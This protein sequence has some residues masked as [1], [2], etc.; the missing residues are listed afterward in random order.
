[1]QARRCRRTLLCSTIVPANYVSPQIQAG[2]PNL[3]RTVEIF[4]ACQ[5]EPVRVHPGLWGTTAVLAPRL[6]AR[7]Q[8]SPG[9]PSLTGTALNTI[10][11]GDIDDIVLR[12]SCCK[13]LLAGAGTYFTWIV[14][15]R[16]F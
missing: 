1:M 2:L 5:I 12:Q 15:T 11:K 3:N 7:Q 16:I 6:R 8:A 13:L 14:L 10:P 4:A 9:G